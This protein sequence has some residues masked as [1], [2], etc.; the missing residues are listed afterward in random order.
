MTRFSAV[1]VLA[2]LCLCAPA[3]DARQ[4]RTPDTGLAVV[5]TAP[6]GEVAALAEANEIRVVFSESMVSLG[7][8]PSEVHSGILQDLPSGARHVPVV[9]H[10]GAD[11]HARSQTSALVCHEL[12][13]DDCV[14]HASRQRPEA[15]QCRHLFLHYADCPLLQTRWYR[16]GGTVD[17]RM[18]FLLRFNQ[19]VRPADVARS[20]SASLEPHA[21]E[22]PPIPADGQA[23]V[24]AIDPDGIRR[25]DAKVAAARATAASTAPVGLHVVNDWDQKTYPPSSDLV[26]F[27]SDVPIQPESW[28]KLTLDNKLRSA[29]GPATP[30]QP[31]SY[32]AHA[33]RAFFIDG[34]Y[35]DTACDPDRW[36]PLKMRAR[37]KVTDFAAATTATDVTGA[38]VTVPKAA[39][40]PKRDF[41]QD[42]SGAITLEDAGFAAQP[43]VHK[44]AVAV[45][46]DLRAND[47]QVLGLSL[48]RH[49]RQL[50]SE[51]VHEFRRWPRRLGE[52]RRHHAAVLREKLQ[53]RSASGRCESNQTS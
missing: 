12:S 19:P 27:E 38:P 26:V 35:C 40:P 48:G 9:R 45:R 20:L 10:D 33:E 39:Q 8:I 32:T 6:Q 31:Q 37:V 36:N 4:L 3:A 28:V 46:A 18:V 17:S 2:S 42:A 47:G 51:R 5:S 49:G 13:G 15:R 50:A 30:E 52:G 1:L 11:L 23:G 21:F 22:A 53:G 29:A 41:V 43:P 7:R 44:Y 14:W 16:R 24:R 25:F 34:F